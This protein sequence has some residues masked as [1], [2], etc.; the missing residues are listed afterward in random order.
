MLS[1]PFVAPGIP[2]RICWLHVCIRR[3]NSSSGVIGKMACFSLFLLSIISGYIRLVF[4]L[5]VCKLAV[6]STLYLS[7]LLQDLYMQ[8]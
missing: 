4:S 7:S 6:D 5:L 8:R 2:F 1:H 3:S